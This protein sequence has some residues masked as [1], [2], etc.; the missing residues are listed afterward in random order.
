LTHQLE[1]R[2]VSTLGAYKVKTRFQAFAF[3]WV[4]FV[5][6]RRGKLLKTE[7]DNLAAGG[8]EVGD[9]L[10]I[11]YSVHKLNPVADP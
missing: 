11:V 9:C 3:K 4:N 1:R 6:L 8:D 5:P 7:L 2:L 10:P